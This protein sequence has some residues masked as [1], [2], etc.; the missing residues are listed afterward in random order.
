MVDL[1]MVE[2]QASLNTQKTHSGGQSILLL[3]Q[4]YYYYIREQLRCVGRCTKNW[5]LEVKCLISHEVPTP[6][7]L[8]RSQ[9]SH[10]RSEDQS[11][12]LI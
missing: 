7:D 9:C 5:Q 4:L 11:L 12:K 6:L 1:L 2:F 10:F 3:S 8:G